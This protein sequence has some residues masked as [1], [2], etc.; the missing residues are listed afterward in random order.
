MITL[1]LDGDWICYTA[2]FAG[3]KTE[4]VYVSPER[5][6]YG[7]FENKTQAKEAFDGKLPDGYKE[8]A[9]T[10][11]DPL[12]HVLHSAK[13]MIQSQIEKV[14]AKFND[15]VQVIVYVD[16]H[17]NFRHQL[18]TIAPYKGN[19][20]SDKPILHNEI[21]QYLIESWGAQE[22][23][24]IETDDQLAIA[25]TLANAGGNKTIICAVDKDMLQVPGWHLNPNKGFKKISEQEALGRLYRQAI[26]GDAV[27]N[28]KGAYKYGPVAA[29]KLIRP[30]MTEDEMWK[31]TVNAYQAS[32]DKYGEDAMLY[33]ELDAEQAALENMRLVYL[34]RGHGDMYCRPALRGE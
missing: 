16:G 13:K 11:T 22:V 29:K 3:Q 19:R 14:E 12:D 10:Y 25:Q 24:D 9:R 4:Y 5:D 6:L 23:Y 15:E 34:Q 27:D 17:G 30:G 8:Y 21:K 33:G 2:G 31:A 28:I 18:A 32:I 26:T 7:P 20:P 1:L